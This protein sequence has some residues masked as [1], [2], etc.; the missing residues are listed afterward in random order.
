VIRVA[1]HPGTQPAV[2]DEEVARVGLLTRSQALPAFLLTLPATLNQEILVAP[3]AAKCVVSEVIYLGSSRKFLVEATS[4]RR[5]EARTS[6]RLAPDL[7]G[8]RPAD[9]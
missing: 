3:I 5:F 6:S 1:A 8:T 9:R 7:R 2:I 4:G